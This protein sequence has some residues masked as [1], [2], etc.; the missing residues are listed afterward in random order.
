MNE[1]LV[2]GHIQYQKISEKGIWIG[3]LEPTRSYFQKMKNDKLLLTYVSIYIYIY[4][5]YYL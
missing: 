3:I 5:F 4:F 1:W 2:Q